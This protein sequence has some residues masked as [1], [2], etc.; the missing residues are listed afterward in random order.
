MKGLRL[1]TM[2]VALLIFSYVVSSTETINGQYVWN[3]FTGQSWPAGYNQNTGKPDSVAWHYDDYDSE[4]FQRINNALP[5]AHVNEA[6]MT[7]DSGSTISLSQ[8]AEVFVTFIHEGAGYK[9]SFGY[10]VFDPENPPQTPE[11]VSEIIVF[12][13]LSYPHLTNGHRVSIGTFPAGTHI[14]FFIAANGFWYYTGVKPSKVPY[15]YSLKHL[16]PEADP[17]LRQHLVLLFDEAVEEV[18]LGFEDLPRTWGDNDFNDAVFSVKASPGSALNADSLVNIPNMNDSDADGVLD[19]S[20]EF[21]NDFQRAYSTYYPNANDYVTLAFEDNWPR[22]GDFDL[23]D[24]V[25]REQLRTIYNSEG[26]IS[27][28]KISGFIDARGAAYHNGFAMRMMGVAPS[29]ISSAQLTI[30]NQTFD[31]TP[32]EFQTDA[33]LVLWQDS[34]DFTQTNGSDKCAHFNTVKECQNFEPVAFELDVRLATTLSALNHS[35]LDFFIFRTNDRS[36]EI[37]F[38]D[39]PPTDLFD[40]T[41]FGR[42]DDTSDADSGRYFRTDNNL[43]WALKIDSQWRYPQ[44]YIDVLWAYPDYETWVESAGEQAQDW[45]LFNGRIHHIY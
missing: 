20:D 11:D 13:N 29:Q 21:P 10:F 12:P 2:T 8:E 25:L 41:R 4:F 16:N 24:L 27:G 38:A 14:G 33:V 18:I 32:E 5:E 43:P 42:L 17:E 45:Y 15:Y 34:H 3:F 22:V 1:G 26:E 23:N 35:S 28:Y 40:E 37:H 7:D 44:E 31:K 6:F 9:N 39:Y 19:D 30:D 36:L